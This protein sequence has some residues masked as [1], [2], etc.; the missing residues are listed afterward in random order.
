MRRNNLK[1]LILIVCLLISFF[2]LTARVIGNPLVTS[3][4]YTLDAD[5]DEGVLVGVEHDTVNDQLQLSKEYVTLPFIWIPNNQGTVSKINT[6]T[7]KE[8][9]R[10]W[11][12]P[13]P[14]TEYYEQHEYYPDNVANTWTCSPSRTTVDLQGNC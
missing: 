12:Q 1:I 3:W 8:L 9:G 5:F 11:V 4:T 14:E 13:N 10:Y 2:G 6:E 7:G